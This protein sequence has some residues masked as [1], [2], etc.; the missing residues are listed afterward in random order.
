MN[1]IED[2]DQLTILLYEEHLKDYSPKDK[3]MKFLD[4]IPFEL[5]FKNI[6]LK[7]ILK[8][9]TYFLRR[10]VCFAKKNLEIFIW[11]LE[12]IDHHLVDVKSEEIKFII[13]Y[14]LDKLDL[15]NIKNLCVKIFDL[16]IRIAGFD[17]RNI[18]ER[19][20]KSCKKIFY[21]VEDSSNVIRVFSTITEIFGDEVDEFINRRVFLEI[22][23]TFLD[24]MIFD[25]F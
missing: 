13:E 5:R 22:L 20:W 12:K 25:D 21:S 1:L 16:F 8:R 6:D 19:V 11:I 18:V 15:E 14:C 10:D 23:F 4:K 17:S 7:A 3:L 9:I 2:F 24:V